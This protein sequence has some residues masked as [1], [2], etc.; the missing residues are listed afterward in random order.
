MSSTMV[1]SVEFLIMGC[2]QL[3]EDRV[4]FE[5]EQ[6][7]FAEQHRKAWELDIPC[8]VCQRV[9]LGEE[10]GS[11]CTRPCRDE[12]RL[13]KRSGNVDG[14]RGKTGGGGQGDV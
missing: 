10:K 9:F 14:V 12:T 3:E 2:G 8:H 4:R 11:T 6:V 13:A 7:L 5:E 1:C